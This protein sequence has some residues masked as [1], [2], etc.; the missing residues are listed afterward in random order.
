MIKANIYL[1]IL[2]L[3]VHFVEK[4]MCIYMC[5]YIVSFVC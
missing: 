2:Y 1:Y 5:I 3:F 4:Y